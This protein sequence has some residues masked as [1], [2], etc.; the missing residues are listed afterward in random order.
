MMCSLDSAPWDINPT[1]L[2]KPKKWCNRK[3]IAVQINCTRAKVIKLFNIKSRIILT[4]RLKLSINLIPRPKP[5]DHNGC[6]ASSDWSKNRHFVFDEL[7]PSNYKNHRKKKSSWN[8]KH[9]NWQGTTAASKRDKTKKILTHFKWEEM[10]VDEEQLANE[11][12]MFNK[13][14]NQASMERQ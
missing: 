6:P 14:Q 1:K 12:P 11:R 5:D 10:K 4:T 7:P 8:Q 2:N 9:S 3:T 13:K